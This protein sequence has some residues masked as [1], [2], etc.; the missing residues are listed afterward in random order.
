[1]NSIFVENPIIGSV[2]GFI[3]GSAI[4]SF[5]N[6]CSTRIPLGISIIS[7]KSNCPQCNQKIPF[8]LNIPVLSWLLL[9]GK[10]GCCD[11]KIPPRYLALELFTGI[12]FSLLFYRFSINQDLGLLFSSL[13]F[14]C[15]MI[16]ITAIDFETMMI[17]DRFSMG[18]AFAGLALSTW[19]PI[20]HGYSID[21]LINERFSAFLLSLFGLLVC[22]SILFWV[23]ALAEN[24]IGKEAL[25]QGD[26]KLLGCVGAFCGW[27]GG[28]FAIFGGA[29]LGTITMIPLLMITRFSK[30]KFRN[31][32]FQPGWGME[33]PFGPFLAVA[34]L[35]Y[36]LFFG[37][38]V[39]AWFEQTRLNF[40]HLFSFM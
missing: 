12:L 29:L 9:K 35:C 2:V 5:L 14:V 13:V 32:N 23:G 24:F 18:G 40:I 1:M 25:G 30:F 3:L 8:Y 15:L 6:V 10:A 39:D 16:V 34:A 31:E 33:I 17:P 36:F 20:I 38:F 7:P 26:V 21:P 4:G 27:Q 22:S 19:F 11:F 28:I 37:E